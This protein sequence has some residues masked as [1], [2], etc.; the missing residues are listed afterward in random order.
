MKQSNLA[1]W[2]RVLASEPERDATDPWPAIQQ[3]V[4]HIQRSRSGESRIFKFPSRAVVTGTAAI[5]V[6]GLAIGVA[7]FA[8]QA[9]TASASEAFQRLEAEAT[10]AAST[11]GPCG[12]GKLASAATGGVVA[13]AGGVDANPKAPALTS[14]DASQL[15]DKL[16]QALGV[17]G[18]RVRQA[19]RQT[20]A[21]DLPSGPPPDPIAGIARQLGM[22]TDQVCAAF[23]NPNA[24][25]GSSVSVGRQVTTG[26]AKRGAVLYINGTEIDLES[27]TAGQLSAPAQKLGVSPDRLLSAIKA[28]VPAPPSPPPN[29][30]SKD[31]LINRFAQ[32]LG[33]SPDK[34]R[35]AMTQVEGPN[36]FYFVVPLPGFGGGSS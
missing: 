17:S 24:Q 16:A 4:V 12:G 33:M 20:L 28:A 29:L 15:S 14:T 32:N 10:S 25:D 7:V 18:D 22:S 19:M 5:L 11:P 21:P 8:N 3:R 35:A 23:A 30:P 31:E 13:M 27:E 26:G 1:V 9:Q 2:L 6:A 34:V 36:R